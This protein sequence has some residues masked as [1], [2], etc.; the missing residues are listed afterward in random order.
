MRGERG[1]QSP[2][3]REREQASFGDKQDFFW[4]KPVPPTYSTFQQQLQ[5]HV[6]GQEPTPWQGKK[7]IVEK[8]KQEL[9]PQQAAEEKIR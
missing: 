3:K 8:K 5:L 7:A 2:R 6:K 9:R 1:R 4:N